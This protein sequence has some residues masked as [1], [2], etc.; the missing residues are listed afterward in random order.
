MADYL[1]DSRVL[2]VEDNL[3][4]LQESV[5]GLQKSQEEMVGT[6]AVIRSLLEQQEFKKKKEEEESTGDS[7]ENETALQVE[8]DNGGVQSLASRLDS[9]SF[10]SGLGPIPY[11]LTIDEAPIGAPLTSPRPETLPIPST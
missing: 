1:L 2:S 5:Q 10:P 3:E 9:T 11:P 4:T 7:S 6:L 8:E